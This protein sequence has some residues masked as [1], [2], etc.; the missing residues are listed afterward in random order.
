MIVVLKKT[1][2]Y[3][4]IQTNNAQNKTPECNFSILGRLTLNFFL[5][6]FGFEDPT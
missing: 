2:A 4:D 3:A 1:F 5:S 6:F